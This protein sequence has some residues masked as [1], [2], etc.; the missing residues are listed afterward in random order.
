M[1][2]LSTKHMRQTVTQISEIQ[3]ITKIIIL[4]A[5][6][7]CDSAPEFPDETSL[8]CAKER[9]QERLLLAEAREADAYASNGFSIKSL[10]ATGAKNEAQKKLID[11]VEQKLST[12]GTRSKSLIYLYRNRQLIFAMKSSKDG[13]KQMEEK[14]FV[15]GNIMNILSERRHHKKY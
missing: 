13:L 14:N 4:F 5:V 15:N 1:D 2:F 10:D 7:G 3:K 12:I 11:L 6:I 8:Q 9:A